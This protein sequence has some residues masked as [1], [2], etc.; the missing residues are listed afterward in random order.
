MCVHDHDLEPTTI[1][2]AILTISIEMIIIGHAINEGVI[3]YLL[4]GK[5]PISIV[6]VRLLINKD[7]IV[8]IL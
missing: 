2:S 1:Q 5:S 3:R 6:I 8:D 7:P 4:G